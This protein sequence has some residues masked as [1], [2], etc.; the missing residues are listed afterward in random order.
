MKTQGF[1]SFSEFYPF[2]LS[3]HSSRINRKFHL[4]GTILFLINFFYQIF[5]GEAFFLL[6]CLPLGY[7]PAWIGHFVFEKNK[8]AT[9]KYPVN[10]FMGDLAMTYDTFT[11]QL[12][13]KFDEYGIKEMA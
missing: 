6:L 4:T 11:G 10:S 9:F 12:K 13:R 5:F 8:P 3:Q 2:Y 1:E 7:G